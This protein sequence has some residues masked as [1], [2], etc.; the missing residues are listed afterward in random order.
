M[1]IEVIRGS[2][3]NPVSSEQLIEIIQEKI[4]DTG[5]LYTGYPILGLETVSAVDALLISKKYGIVVFDLVEGAL[6]EDRS[7]IRDELYNVLHS[8]LIANKELAAKRGELKFGLEVATFAPA[9]PSSAKNTSEIIL[10][11]EDLE[12]YF[13]ELP[14]KSV[15]DDDFR[16]LLQVIQAI[17][18]LRHKTSRTV[19]KPNSKG[20]FLNDIENSIA[21]LDKNQSKAVIET[22]MGIQRI[23]GLAGSGKT[24]VLAL[25]VAYLHSKNPDWDIA[26]TFFTRSL[27]NI[28]VDFINKFCIDQT[29]QEPDWNKIKILQAWGGPSDDGIYYQFCKANDVEYYDVNRAKEKFGSST[30][31]IDPICAEALSAATK[32]NQLYDLILVD[33]AQDFTDS[34]LKVCY[35]LLRSHDRN[36]P[37]NK[38][39]IYAYD[40]L[41]KLN[42]SGRLGN[43]KT[44]FGPEIDFE[45]APN[46]PK[47]DIILDCC[48]RNSGPVLVTAHA[49]GFGIYADN[50]LV[51]M[52]KEKEIW[53]DVGY[54][55]CGGE[56]EYGK[57]VELKRRPNASPDF[58][59]SHVP[60]DDLI[61]FKSFD[62]YEKQNIEVANEIKSNL[63][64]DELKHRDIIVVHPNPI[65][66]KNETGDLRAL[67]FEMGIRSH[68]AGVNTSP[69]TFFFDDSIAFTSIY[70]AKG[71]EAA[72]VYVIFSEHCHS[73]YELLK[74][75]NTLFTA[76]TRSKGWV[77]V[78]GVGPRMDKLVK[79]FDLTKRNRFKL[80]FKYPTVKEM[81]D[82]NIINR[83]LTDDEKMAIGDV[84][85]LTK[86]IKQGN[87]RKLDLSPEELEIWKRFL[88]ED[89]T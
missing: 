17:T 74:R 73:G 18:K 45:N 31:H 59:L 46:K 83:D 22:T 26:I 85:S 27:K 38:R 23:R 20:R 43:P 71:N 24:V 62:S 79:E 69:D 42:D 72:M 36:N 33:E 19:S 10:S 51:T 57:S 2:S 66:T 39:L 25:K 12:I 29:N 3:A 88:N 49:L 14:L 35:T 11:K 15:T 87:V 89:G 41:Q 9:W 75:R 53:K 44:I 76:I 86:K 78:Y 61:I 64:V 81:D 28:F 47:Q 21:N 5:Y 37:A 50:G 8:K 54:E 65:R 55:V 16:K 13:S 70:R 34:F 40:E 30:N 4:D 84:K 77:R 68:L 67:L 56:L 48:Y 1:M 60:I 58:I 63:E 6:I 7:D 82:L 52:F 32:F 80:N